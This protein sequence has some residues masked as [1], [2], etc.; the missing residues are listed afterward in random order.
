[1]KITDEMIEL[2]PTE[3]IEAAQKLTDYF[4]EKNAKEWKLIGVQNRIDETKLTEQDKLLERL[5]ADLEYVRG[6]MAIVCEK[7]YESIQQ[8]NQY[9]AGRE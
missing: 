7:S 5:A 1:M 9:K 4:A 2:L 6:G 8:Y 3:I